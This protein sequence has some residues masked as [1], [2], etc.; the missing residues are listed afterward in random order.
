[1]VLP[2]GPVEIG[3]WCATRFERIY[4]VGDVVTDLHQLTVAD[5][6]RG[7]RRYEHSQPTS[8]EFPVAAHRRGALYGLP[9]E[10]RAKNARIRR[11]TASAAAQYVDWSA[12]MIEDTPCDA[13]AGR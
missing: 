3:S 11:Q 8:S 1:M 9:T 5:R 2:E 4:A 13:L 6:S 12:A 7:G 10:L